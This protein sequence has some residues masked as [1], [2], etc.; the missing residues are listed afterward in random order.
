MHDVLP[1]Q[2]TR[3]LSQ[4]WLWNSSPNMAALPGG[5]HAH[6]DKECKGVRQL[7]SMPTRPELNSESSSGSKADAST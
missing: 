7:T 2:Q 6:A 3:T 1:R 4:V 5:Q